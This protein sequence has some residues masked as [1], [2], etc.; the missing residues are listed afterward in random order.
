M[1]S[2]CEACNHREVVGLLRE[3]IA[4]EKHNEHH[5]HTILEAV[6]VDPTKL[7]ELTAQL[8]ART[9]ALNAAIAANPVPGE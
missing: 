6:V 2:N 8:N 1:C 5:L 9:E 4:R 7:A 3:I